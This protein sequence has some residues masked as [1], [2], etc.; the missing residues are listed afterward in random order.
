MPSY[1]S[2][3]SNSDEH[4]AVRIHCLE[5]EVTYASK[6]YM[7]GQF[8]PQL[9]I[10]FGPAPVGMHLLAE[11]A[12]IKQLSHYGRGRRLGRGT[13]KVT[14]HSGDI[15]EDEYEE[16]EPIKEIPVCP[17]PSL[18]LA[19]V[20][21]SYVVDDATIVHAAQDIAFGS[22]ILL[23]VSPP[24]C[25]D[26]HVMLNFDAMSITRG[27]PVEYASILIHAIEA[28]SKSGAVFLRAPTPTWSEDTVTWRSAPEYDKVIGSLSTIESGMVSCVCL[29]VYRH[30]H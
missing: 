26:M 27:S 13:T 17:D 8:A 19:M 22:D 25:G 24:E 18:N 28:S 14:T 7:E 2:L 1:H 29:Y 20:Q 15:N 30:Y 4:V 11:R 23:E 21:R 9:I 12:N 10:E 3:V 16:S 6:E 5:N